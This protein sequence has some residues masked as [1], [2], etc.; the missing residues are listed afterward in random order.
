[1]T[2]RA[3]RNAANLETTQK[4]KAKP[5]AS[6]H[7][8]RDASLL[9]A[10]LLGCALLGVVRAPG[11][12]DIGRVVTANA[13]LTSHLVLLT[14]GCLL[15][16]RWR[17]T[18]EP[19]TAW[20]AAAFLVP[21]F[22]LVPLAM[23]SV[24]DQPPAWTIDIGAPLDLVSSV[25]ILA[26]A[27]LAARKTRFPDGLNPIE[28]AAALGVACLGLA[29]AAVALAPPPP[30]ATIHAATAL[31]VILASAGVSRLTWLRVAHRTVLALGAAG[32][33]V[34]H[35]FHHV[36]TVSGPIADTPEFMVASVGV[37]SSVVI[38]VLTLGLFRRALDL[39][40][41]R[42]AEYQARAEAAEEWLRRE[43]ELM[44]EVRATMAGISSA[45]YV[46]HGRIPM[47]RQ[48]SE[49]HLRTMLDTEV[50]RVQRLLSGHGHG[51]RCRIELDELILPQVVA[52]RAL[53][54]DVH[55]EPSGVAALGRPDK[56]A[57]AVHVMLT[58][59][60][61]YSAGGPVH[62]QASLWGETAS[63]TITDSGP[64]VPQ[65]MRAAIFERGT[66]DARSP[67]QGVGLYLA[68]KAVQEDGGSIRLQDPLPGR[69]AAFVISLRA[70]HEEDG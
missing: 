28:L 50:A 41:R 26:F 38:V 55:W 42:I 54:H 60:T 14:G 61:R 39:K 33:A 68:Q 53:G 58:N 62:V 31:A 49:Q 51:R 43:E 45:T 18:R 21:S 19:G 9:S 67:G 65:H 35:D 5:T 30:A 37:V 44:H 3:A 2:L 1:M 11:D 10:A 52:Q 47:Q 25:P 64:G 36:A 6:L 8:G 7:L 15:H 70:A 13:W 29:L 69:G 17:V 16:A 24:T 57:E 20:L 46:L 40:A 27:V 23:L 12:T 4:K 63:I 66:H 59:A 56:L 34:A 22:Q 48:V 32:T